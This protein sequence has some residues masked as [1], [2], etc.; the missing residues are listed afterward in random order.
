M[1]TCTNKVTAT[2]CWPWR[3]DAEKG[4]ATEEEGRQQQQQQQQ[5]PQHDQDLAA[6]IQNRGEHI[7]GASTNEQS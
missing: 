5:W 2:S 1:L 7:L 3:R 6:L 4:G